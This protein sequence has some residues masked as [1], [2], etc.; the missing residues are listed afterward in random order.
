MVELIRFVINDRMEIKT[1]MKLQSDELSEFL[2]QFEDN[3]IISSCVKIQ[4]HI[5]PLRRE[6]NFLSNKVIFYP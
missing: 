3:W 4:N 6:P 5:H 2:F 1:F